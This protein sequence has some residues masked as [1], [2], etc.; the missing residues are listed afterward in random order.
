MDPKDFSKLSPEEV[1][2]LTG[3][4]KVAYDKWLGT[5][6]KPGKLA[7]SKAPAAKPGKLAPEP[8]QPR[9]AEELGDDYFERHPDSQ[10]DHLW[11]TSDEQIFPG[12]IQGKNHAENYCTEQKN[13]GS[14]L[15]LSKYNR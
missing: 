14:P 10:L 11:I 6:A 12:T 5:S 3:D 15:Q 2:A 1:A 7:P 9:S 4:D 13:A 8:K